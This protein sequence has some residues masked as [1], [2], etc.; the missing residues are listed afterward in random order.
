[1]QQ[2]CQQGDFPYHVGEINQASRSVGTKC[3]YDNEYLQYLANSQIVVTSSPT[4]WEGDSRTWEALGNG[5]LVFVDKMYVPFQD[6]PEHNK[7]VIE[8]DIGDPQSLITPLSFCLQNPSFGRKIADAGK[9]W[10]VEKHSPKA[11]MAEVVEYLRSL[12]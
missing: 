10:A 6:K 2:F 4:W 3:H 9:K 12:L 11:R 1:M 8:Y 7:H 5:A